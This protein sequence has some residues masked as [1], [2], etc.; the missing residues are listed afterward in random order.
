MREHNLHLERRQSLCVSTG[1]EFSRKA[2]DVI[3]LY[4]NPPQ[5]ALVLCVDEKPYIDSA[6]TANDRH[7]AAAG[8]ISQVTSRDDETFIKARH[9]LQP[10]QGIGH[11]ARTWRLEE[12]TE[13]QDVARN[14]VPM[15]KNFKKIS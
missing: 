8:K 6:E 3:G 12:S 14:V 13:L 9:T 2:A 15:R 11:V 5:N 4:L 10:D 1:P 7:E